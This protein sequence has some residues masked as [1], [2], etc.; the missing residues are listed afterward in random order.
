MAYL[1]AGALV[2]SALPALEPI[3]ATALAINIAYLN[4]ERFRYRKK[5]REP[6]REQ[7]ERLHRFD[8]DFLKNISKQDQTVELV[9]LAGIDDADKNN[10]TSPPQRPRSIGLWGW[11]Y[12]LLFHQHIDLWLVG[13]M[14][15]ISLMALF[16]GPIHE[17]NLAPWS[18]KYFAGTGAWVSW[19]VLLL[20]TLLPIAFVFMGRRVVKWGQGRVEHTGKQ[21]KQLEMLMQGDAKEAA[22]TFVTEQTTSEE[23][24]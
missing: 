8:G 5:I 18:E 15:A 10:P 11:V 6:A 9:W 17:L 1:D 3:S 22:E 16:I 7:L 14:T 21:L 13:I 2:M 12:N 24:L 19:V 23:K 20:C 4:L